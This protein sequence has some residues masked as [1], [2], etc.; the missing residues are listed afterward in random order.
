MSTGIYCCYKNKVE[1]IMQDLELDRE[2]ISI[3]Q[4]TYLKEKITVLLS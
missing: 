1:E 2:D 4:L 3:S